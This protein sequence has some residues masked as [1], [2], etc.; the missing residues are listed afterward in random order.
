LSRTKLAQNR[1][2]SFA[3]LIFDYSGR[4]VFGSGPRS[5]GRTSSIL[6]FPADTVS[7][8]RRIG[9]LYLT[10]WRVRKRSVEHLRAVYMTWLFSTK[11]TISRLSI[12]AVLQRCSVTQPT[13]VGKKSA[14]P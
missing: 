7:I 5:P 10:T 9:P 14:T 6:L 13:G 2:L 11:L 1:Y 4:I 8:H 3:L 12:Q